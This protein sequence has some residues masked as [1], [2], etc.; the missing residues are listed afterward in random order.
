MFS[1]LL[2]RGFARHARHCE[3]FFL[4]LRFVAAGLYS[5]HIIQEF[6][7]SRDG[8]HIGRTQRNLAMSSPKIGASS[9]TCAGEFMLMHWGGS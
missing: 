8:T 1:R 2:T 6:V 3:A 4:S 5:R 9:R 7:E